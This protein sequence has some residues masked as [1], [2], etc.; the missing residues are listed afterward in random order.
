MIYTFLFIKPSDINFFF[1]SETRAQQKGSAF[2]FMKKILGN[3]HWNTGHIRTEDV[4]MR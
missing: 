4:N 1:K 3:F 2:F